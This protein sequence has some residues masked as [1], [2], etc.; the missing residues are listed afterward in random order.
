MVGWGWAEGALNPAP[1]PGCVGAF[2]KTNVS[3]ICHVPVGNFFWTAWASHGL[4]VRLHLGWVPQLATPTAKMQ[5]QKI[6]HNI[7][8]LIATKS[9]GSVILPFTARGSGQGA[10]RKNFLC[11]RNFCTHEVHFKVNSF[12]TL[13]LVAR[14]RATSTK[15]TDQSLHKWSCH[16]VCELSSSNG[17]ILPLLLFIEHIWKTTLR[18][19]KT[20]SHAEAGKVRRK[21]ARWSVVLWIHKHGRHHIHLQPMSAHKVPRRKWSRIWQLYP[22]LHF[23]V[24]NEPRA[25]SLSRKPH[26]REFPCTKYSSTKYWRTQILRKFP[27]NPIGGKFPSYPCRVNFLECMGGGGVARNFLARVQTFKN[28]FCSHPHPVDKNFRATQACSKT[29]L[30]R[31]LWS[32]TKLGCSV[33]TLL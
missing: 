23:Q 26:P 19:W 16:K 32:A 20:A 29:G 9:W 3:A 18:A 27:C 31:E 22:K 12:S 13:R 24:E 1:C 21:S 5:V 33:P 4:S 28:I 11:L 14:I 15:S 30:T 6:D 10:T 17:R 2:M 7:S 8:K 25:A